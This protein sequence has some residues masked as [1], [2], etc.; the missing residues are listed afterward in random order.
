MY[1][2]NQFS[3]CLFLLIFILLPV[4]IVSVCSNLCSGRGTC[5]QF[6]RCNCFTDAKGKELYSNYDC[7][8]RVCPKGHAWAGT[9]A[10]KANDMHPLVECK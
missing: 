5:E 3:F 6:D 4:Q 2:Y 9:V 7:S 10:V 1:T 8:N